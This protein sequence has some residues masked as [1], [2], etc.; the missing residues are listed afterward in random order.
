[1][2]QS[3]R[4]KLTIWYILITMVVSLLF[5]FAIY[6]SFSQELDR[7]ERAQRLRTELQ[8]QGFPIPPR[9]PV[10]IELLEEG[11]NHLQRILLSINLAILGISAAAGYFLAG[12]TLRPIQH[13]VDKQNQFI[14]D[15]SHELRTP[16]TALKTGIEVNL[17]DKSLTLKQAKTVLQENLSDVEKLR[18]L[19]DNL[20]TLS[21]LQYNNRAT[22]KQTALDDVIKS[23]I[24]KVRPLARNK[25]ITIKSSLS[26]LWVKGDETRL[27]DLFVIFLDNAIKYSPEKTT[28]TIHMEKSDAVIKTSIADQGMGIHEKDIPHIFER[29]YRVDKSRSTV[30]TDGYGLGLAIAHEILTSH[31][32]SVTVESTPD[33][34]STFII[35][36]PSLKT[37]SV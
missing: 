9:R 17:R 19:S 13:M 7:F 5:S 4:V 34:G 29:F 23:S 25:H 1:M 24:E 28:I 15:A 27:V 10:N 35:S 22:F 8:V 12:R 31:K 20:L 33:K 14:T 32:G 26:K 16:L 21:V 2:F 11:R 3:A 36:L 18:S 30:H 6:Q 37:P